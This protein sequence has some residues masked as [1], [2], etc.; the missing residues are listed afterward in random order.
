MPN[1]FRPFGGKVTNSFSQMFTKTRLT[2]TFVYVIILAAILISSGAISRSIFIDRLA[3]RFE[4]FEAQLEETTDRRPPPPQRIYIQEDF[5]ETIVIVNGLLLLLAGLLSYGLAGLTLRPIQL[6]YERQ[7]QF[8]SD[9]S[10][11]LRTPLAIL[12][13]DLENQLHRSTSDRQK[14]ELE[15]HL[16]EVDRMSHLV[17]DLLHLSRMTERTDALQETQRIDLVSL[18]ELSVKRLSPL[19][20][21][22]DINLTYK[23]TETNIC[24]L[25]NQELLLQ[26]LA[27][28]IKNAIAYNKPKGTVDVS[29]NKEKQ[30]AI[31]TIEDSGIGIKETD[32]AQIFNR[33]YR[34]DK[35]RSRNTGGSGLGLSIT[36]SIIQA[37]KGSISIKSELKKGTI[38]TISLPIHKTS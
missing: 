28:V 31:V 16:E 14:D 24:V 2:L 18:L 27:N 25:G 5:Q 1:V 29:L 37:H 26:A 11:E 9:A 20:K 8:L 30:T 4:T 36:Q 3:Y 7:R 23:G 15:S 32:Q 21:S 19:A 10:H 6:A 17:D 22:H 33:F 38:V 12:K 35:S 13:T 34:V